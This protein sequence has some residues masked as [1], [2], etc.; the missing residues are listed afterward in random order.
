MNASRG[1]NLHRP[2]QD[3]CRERPYTGRTYRNPQYMGICFLYTLSVLLRLILYS[4]VQ[5]PLTVTSG[6]LPV[7]AVFFHISHVDFFDLAFTIDIV[8][9]YVPW[10]SAAKPAGR[11]ILE[12][13]PQ[14]R[15]ALTI[16]SRSSRVVSLI[17]MDFKNSTSPFH[18]SLRKNH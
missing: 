6:D 3:H 16:A 14:S 2:I 18:G 11:T 15:D 9:I 12:P 13:P 7:L 1:Y 17:R 4:Q 5:Y 10:R 8:L